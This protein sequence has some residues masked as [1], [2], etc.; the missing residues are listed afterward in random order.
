MSEQTA[1]PLSWPIGWKRNTTR[2]RSRFGKWNAPPSVSAATR[3]VLDELRRMGV[4]DWHVVISTNLELRNDGLPYSNRRPP[5]DP[6]AAVYFQL[7][8]KKKVLACDKY[9]TVGE[10]LYAIGL[11]IEATR[12]IE[13]WGSVTT[14][15][16]FAGYVALQEKT[17]DNCWE[18]LCMPPI[19]WKSQPVLPQAREVAQIAIME[20]WRRKVKLAHPDVL[21]GSSEEFDRINRAKD[22]ALQLIGA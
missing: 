4:G 1:Y 3:F 20:A 9:Q 17:E 2:V 6:G 10:N 7:N 18:V 22:M 13:R 19:Q 11:T 12:G 5:S 16:A 14:E 15:Q 21:G 8:G